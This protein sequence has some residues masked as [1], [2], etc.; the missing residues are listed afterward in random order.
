[1]PELIDRMQSAL[2]LAGGSPGLSA[3]FLAG[4][5]AL[6]Y[7]KYSGRQELGSL[8][9]YGTVTLIIVINPAF[10]LF[11]TNVL[12][13]LTTDNKMLW[14]LPVVPVILVAGVEAFPFEREK[15]EKFLFVAAVLGLLLLA[16]ASSY[17]RNQNK[18]AYNAEYIPDNVLEMILEVEQYREK[19]NRETV[20][21]WADQDIMNYARVYTGNIYLLYGKDL[22]LGMI[23]SQLH[24]IYED[25]HREAYIM[26]E[27]APLY[28]DKIALVAEERECDVLILSKEIFEMYETEIPKSLGEGQFVYYLSGEDYVMY[29][30]VFYAE[31]YN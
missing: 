1:M 11:V 31:N 4:L 26:M 20:L 8:F 21:L 3:L 24:Q 27:N 14:I 6:W 19:N 30:P 22:W 16:G 29:V 25:W 18:A 5:L 9:W 28:L 17:T 10:F 7:Y 2:E 12:P 13:E 15:K 23:D